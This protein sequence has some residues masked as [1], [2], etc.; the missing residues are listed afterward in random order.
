VSG[1]GR[2][3]NTA[4]LAAVTG[5][6]ATSPSG[7]STTPA[8][9]RSSRLAAGLTQFVVYEP[10]TT[11]IIGQDLTA[12]QIEESLGKAVAVTFGACAVL[13]VAWRSRAHGRPFADEVRLSQS[14]DAAAARASEK[15]TLFD[16]IPVVDI[17][18]LNQAHTFFHRRPLISNSRSTTRP[19]DH[20]QIRDLQYPAGRGQRRL[21]VGAGGPETSRGS[22]N[23]SS[24]KRQVHSEQVETSSMAMNLN[25]RYFPV[26]D[27][28]SCPNCS[29]R[30]LAVARKVLPD[31]SKV[32]ASPQR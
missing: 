20:P 15:S 3:R 32:T 25:N 9:A 21:R 11:A 17:A 30:G 8:L 2:S 27:E 7:F 12:S 16:V 23:T 14:A 19:S 22:P 6:S 29:A 18:R 28:N 10:R 24:R 5:V 4:D 26:N 1:S 31:R 13:L